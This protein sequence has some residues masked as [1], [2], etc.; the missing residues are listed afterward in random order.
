MSIATD[1]LETIR[2]QVQY[3]LDH[4][5]RNQLSPDQEQALIAQIKDRLVAE[6]AVIVAH[7]Y[8]APAIQ[9]LAEESG[10]C[11]SDSLEMARFGHDHSASTLIVAG[12]KFM[13]ET[14]KILTPDKRVLMPT[15]EATCSL[16][17]GCPA[18][19]FAAF[20]DQHP[21]REVV[22]YA[23]TSAAVKA[24]ADWVVTS[25]IALDVA[26]HL[27][28][29]GKKIIWAPDKHLGDYVQRQTGADVLMWD[30]ACI[31]HEEF[32]ARGIADLKNVYPDAAVLVH[33][34][35]PASVLELADRVGSTTQII[36]AAQEMD[37][38]RFIVATD[39]GIFYKLQQ[40]A[41]GKEFII[42][43]TAGN[44]ASCRSCANCPWMAMNE[45]ESLATVFD[46]D[47]NEI[48]VD[49]ILGK[50]AMVPLRRMLDFAAE[51]QVAVKGNA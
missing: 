10:G 6:N 5:E 27:H 31:V 35:S 38:E 33:P 36:R 49:P 16:D 4:A 34:E 39:Q 22:V 17:L 28:D 47:D 13:G 19:E 15:L 40:Q 3:H 21:D 24:R 11:V 7:Y 51:L 32:K 41:P 23:N 48:F 46:R 20:C 14:A 8:T 43:P 44:G 26:E 25:S 2:Q 30:G 29:Q 50:Q 1:K 18:D 42:A 45:L 12:V 9:A 37:R